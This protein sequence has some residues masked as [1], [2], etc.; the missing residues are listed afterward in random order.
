MADYEDAAS[1]SLPGG[2]RTDSQLGDVMGA[3][4]LEST[5]GTED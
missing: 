2:L 1:G 5:R 4:A 3:P